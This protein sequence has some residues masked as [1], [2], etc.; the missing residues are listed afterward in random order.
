MIESLRYKGSPAM[1]SAP[2]RPVRSRL[3]TYLSKSVIGHCLIRVRRRPGEASQGRLSVMG[4]VMPCALGKGGVS[5]FK[6]EGDGATPRGRSRL[7]RVWLRSGPG[8]SLPV[9]LPVRL[10]TP[11]DGWCDDIRSARY[12][13]PVRMP[14]PLS[15]ETMWRHDHLYDIVIEIGWND[16]PAIRGRGSAIFMHL[17]RPG[18][19]PT[20]GCVALSRRDMMRLLPYLTPRTWIDIA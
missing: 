10:T 1:A 11:A 4:L 8:R 15:H 3:F 18:Y 20:E 5:A 17:A 6:R 14:F 19:T 12:N 2:P 9:R 13:R 7:R 16:Q